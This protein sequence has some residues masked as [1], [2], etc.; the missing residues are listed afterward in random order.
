MLPVWIERCRQWEHRASCA[1]QK[2]SKI[3][4]SLEFGEN[5]ICACGQGTL[6]RNFIPNLPQWESV[7]RYAVR[8]AISPSFSVPYVE[9]AYD[10]RD[11]KKAGRVPEE[12]CEAC[13]KKKF[14]VGGQALKQCARCQDVKY[15][16]VE[17]QRSH[18]QKHKRLCKK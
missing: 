6:P 2:T 4:L 15:C 14:E 11:I 17:C 10:L 16:S 7:A 18:W 3:P 13:G 1:Y 8:A 12:G 9:Q 5:P